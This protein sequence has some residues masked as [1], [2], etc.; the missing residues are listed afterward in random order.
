MGDILHSTD[1][2]FDKEVLK[3]SEPVLVD[4]WA[5]WCMPCRTMAPILE[6]LAVEQKGKI[7]VVKLD[8]DE[9]SETASKFNITS[10]PTMILFE[11]G[12]AQKTLVGAK[13]KGKLV[14]ELGDWLS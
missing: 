11:D 8:V 1:A 7:K 2:T 6:D 12:Q 13:T 10:I 5:A 14:E 9:N 3:A 4:F